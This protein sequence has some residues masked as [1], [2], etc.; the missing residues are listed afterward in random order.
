MLETKKEEKMT[1]KSLLRTF[2][3]SI[4]TKKK[5]TT[6]IPVISLTFPPLDHPFDL[7]IQKK[8]ID[9]KAKQQAGIRKCKTGAFQTSQPLTGGMLHLAQNCFV[10][11]LNL[12][13]AY[14]LPG[15]KSTE[16]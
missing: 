2:L 7:E 3:I 10:I 13:T 16:E 9:L 14:L 6:S 12:S 8:V 5:K 1:Q 11:G 4:Q 15:Y